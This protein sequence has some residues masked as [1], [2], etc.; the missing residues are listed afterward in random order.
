MTI[1]FKNQKYFDVVKC[2]LKEGINIMDLYTKNGKPLQVSGNI[3]YSKSGI[4]FGKILG[5]KV[6]GTNGHYVG[7]II[8][9]RLV[10]RST[11]SANVGS[12]F[13]VANRVGFARA[14]R[15]GSAIMGDEPKVP[16]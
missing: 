12:S 13:C 1:F 14:N 2:Y 6:F 5:S 7:T 11:D 3:V 10:F 16:D 8:N 9:E 4:A 15:V